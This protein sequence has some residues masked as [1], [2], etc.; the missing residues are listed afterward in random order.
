ME[1]FLTAYYSL[2]EF[3]QVLVWLFGLSLALVSCYVGE[4][5]ATNPGWFERTGLVIV[6]WVNLVI[7]FLLM[8]WIYIIGLVFAAHITGSLITVVV[9][10]TIICLVVVVVSWFVIA[11]VK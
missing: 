9:G 2:N 5:S 6:V 7:P 3:W 8:V 1:A 10:I 11:Y 4:R